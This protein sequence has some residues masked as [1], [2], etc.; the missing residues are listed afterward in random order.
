MTA[1]PELPAVHQWPV[2]Q[3]TE[4]VAVYRKITS[5]IFFSQRSGARQSGGLGA[6][7]AAY[8][9]AQRH[10]LLLGWWGIPFGLLWTPLTL[11]DNKKTLR[12]AMAILSKG[13]A[14]PSWLSDPSGKYSERFW[15]GQAW[16]DQVRS[17]STD[18][19]TLDHGD[20]ASASDS[21]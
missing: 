1:E 17:T 21:K 9:K 3:V 6:H 16:T 18:L 2:P 4:V 13:V 19:P 14:G 15:N 8:R 20:Q 11:W 7:Y 12:G 10:T 5:V